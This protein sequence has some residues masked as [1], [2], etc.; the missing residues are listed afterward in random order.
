MGI[1][2]DKYITEQM[3]ALGR[4]LKGTS[5]KPMNGWLAISPLI[6]FLTV[7]LVSS[8]I[9]KDFYTV[10]VSSAFIVASIYAIVISRGKSLEERMTVFSR[11]AGNSN[12]MLMIWI[13]ILAGA[14]AATAKQIGAIDATVNLALKLLPGKLL[15][16]GLFIAACFISMSIGT[17]VGTIAALVPIGADIAAKIDPLGADPGLTAFITA[18]IVGG[19]LFGDNLSFI[20]DTT[21]AAT[22]TQGCSMRDKFKANIRIVGPAALIVCGLYIFLGLSV[23]SIPHAGS[24]DILLIIPYL[25]IIILALVGLDVSVVLTTGLIIT[26]V[27]GFCKG[28]L[29]WTGWMQAIGNGIASM[30]DLIIVTLLAGGMLEMIRFNGGLDFITRGLTKNIHGKRGAELSIAGLVSL[31]N[32]CTAN[33]TI[34]I[35]TSGSI[36]KGIT[37]RF[38][39]DPRKTASILDTFSCLIQGFIPYGAQL[40]M[41]AGLA[42]ISSLSI[43]TYLYYPFVMGAFALLAI[44]FRLPRK[45]S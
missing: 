38:G 40:L 8:I 44:L 15:Y 7:Y 1:I 26:A 37:E 13:F 6:V 17:S 21:I 4:K 27:I 9:A 32:I 42:G 20:S 23:E 5:D 45:Y 10:P 43:T 30:S 39:L 18:I 22:R 24:V 31:S 33:N 25:L 2:P 12:I 16:A 35:I 11:G 34:A 36:A 14:F 19:A 29:T 3:K 28:L 41:A